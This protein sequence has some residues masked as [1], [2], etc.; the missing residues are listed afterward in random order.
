MRTH[1]IGV[2][3]IGM[4]G[5]ARLLLAR[6]EWVS[7]CDLV[8]NGLF[9]MLQRSGAHLKAGHAASHIHGADRVIYS[10][11][12]S[13]Q[14]PELLAARNQGLPVL[15]RGQMAAE[16][17]SGKKTIAVTGAHGK[18][19]TAALAASLL[20]K[21]GLDPTILLGAQVDA[22]GGN[23]R[24]GR[25]RYAVIEADDSDG[26]LLWLAP[27][28]AILTNVDEEH[29]DYFRNRAEILETY[30]A[31]LERV[32]PQ[33]AVIGCVDDPG[34]ESL[35]RLN[36]GRGIGYGLSE[37][38]QVRA[39]EI[40]QG[41]GRAS[42]LCLHS[43]RRLGRIR[44]NLTG[45][46]HL[47]NSLAAV[48]LGEWLGIKF[49]TVQESLAG[50]QGAQRRFEVHGEEAGVLVVE[51]YAHHPQEI[52]S[53]L[54]AARHWE[55]R[56]I[57]CVFQPHRYTRTHYLF[58]RFCSS[59]GLADEVILLPI[60]AASEDPMDGVDSGKIVQ[61]LQGQGRRARLFESSEEL[62]TWLASDARSGEMILFMGAGSVGELA[63]QFLK[64]LRKIQGRGR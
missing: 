6:G 32:Q 35:L 36:A 9:K 8:A 55:G 54:Q 4:S 29:L 46:H 7:G 14:N 3:G 37:K 20:V 43:G 31:F 1:L 10:S 13:A 61:R 38:A 16:L 22:L 27:Y 2:G 63:P 59:L 48:A 50:Y 52:R 53:T 64:A 47:V 19:T 45:A 12:V 18:S 24:L 30:E 42:Y 17:V 57:R 40:E 39:I 62:L 58:D 5:I 23:A 33:G 21:A 51:D 56:R 41:A 60:Y 25:G 44:L 34:V 49:S 15:H 26:S 11:S 28:A